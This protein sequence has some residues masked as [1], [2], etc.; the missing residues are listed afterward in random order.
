MFSNIL[1]LVIYRHPK[2]LRKFRYSW[3]HLCGADTCSVI[4]FVLSTE[5]LI[6][7]A[8]CQNVFEGS[9][10]R[11]WRRFGSRPL[12]V[13]A[14]STLAKWILGRKTLRQSHTVWKIFCREEGLEIRCV[15]DD[16][17]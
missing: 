7:M 13:S 17:F 9:M 1:V 5:C 6:Q 16:F 3:E 4:W 8:S 12:L 10:N 14:S 15:T 2:D 11:I